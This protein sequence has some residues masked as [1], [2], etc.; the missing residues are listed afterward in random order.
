[1]NYRQLDQR[2][3][4]RELIKYTWECSQ[5]QLLL[6]TRDNAHR[7]NFIGMGQLI[8]IV[9]KVKEWKNNQISWL[10]CKATE[11]S[12]SD[13]SRTMGIEW[14]KTFL[15]H[16]LNTWEHPESDWSGMYAVR[17]ISQTKLRIKER[18]ESMEIFFFDVMSSNGNSKFSSFI[19]IALCL[20]TH[21]S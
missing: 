9:R 1:M 18:M 2:R 8:R 16:R 6:E 19:F 11:I 20:Q 13:S 5:F 14:N 17:C 10:V 21:F 4:A 15:L 3:Y 12:L 7:S